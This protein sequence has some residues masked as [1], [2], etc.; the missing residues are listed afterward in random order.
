MV[1]PV[2]EL[3]PRRRVSAQGEAEGGTGACWR[4]SEDRGSRVTTVGR[5]SRALPGGSLASVDPPLRGRRG[6]TGETWFPPCPNYHRV[7][8][9]PLKEKLKEAREGAGTTARRDR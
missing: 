7:D 6:L 5:R 1:S 9:Y 8:G 3:P 2:S 4:S